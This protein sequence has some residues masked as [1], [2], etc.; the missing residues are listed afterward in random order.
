MGPMN[1]ALVM[2][3][4][5][6]QKL[7]EAQARLEAVSRNVRVQERKV[8]EL[9]ERLKLAQSRL[10]EN[11]S[12]AANFE[13][14]LKTREA[15]ID[16]LREQQTNAKNNREYQAFLVEINT[17]KADMAKSEE[18]LLKVMEL[19]E[20]F[21][22]ENKEMVASLASEQTRLKAMQT[23]IGERMKILQAEIAGLQPLRDT[24]AAAVPARARDAFDRLADRFEGEAMSALAKPDRRREEYA[25]TSCNMDL[26]TDVY[27]KLH[28]RDE[29]MF[30]PSCHRIL[31]IPD[32]LPI[33]MA[34]NKVKEK[35]EPRVKTS[36]LKA[37][38]N[39]QTAAEAVLKS[40]AVEEDPAPAEEGSGS[41]ASSSEEV[42][43]QAGGESGA[44]DNNQSQS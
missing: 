33:E 17:E 9:A 40:I 26:V 2:L 11:Q 25:C 28:S 12:H 37:G 42:H 30:C 21:Q 38:I 24:A 1:V 10:K 13:L 43:T 15:K 7:R 44:A 14:D 4:R 27:N 23:E 39:R 29:L 36:N 20:K 22:A 32:D 16:R 31:Y 19:V 5:A 8:N 41:D 34:V 6:D 35:K 3:Y 18:E